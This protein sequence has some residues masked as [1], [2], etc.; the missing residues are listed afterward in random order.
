MHALMK[1]N[2]QDCIVY[3]ELPHNMLLSLVLLHIFKYF[4]CCNFSN[5]DGT[6]RFSGLQFWGKMLVVV[7]EV[8]V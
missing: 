5:N 3:T 7:T 1:C 4:I 8:V 2:V 6:L